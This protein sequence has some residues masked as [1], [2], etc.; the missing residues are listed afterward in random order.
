MYL[1]V[2]CMVGG[3]VGGDR[4]RVSTILCDARWPL[5]EGGGRGKV[6]APIRCGHPKHQGI[7]TVTRI[8]YSEKK[9]RISSS[10]IPQH[11]R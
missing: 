6:D 10:C 1:H 4:V 8:D 2:W 7:I 5:E 9:R 3:W 11:T